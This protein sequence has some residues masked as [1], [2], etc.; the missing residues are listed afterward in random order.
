MNQRKP[1]PMYDPK[2]CLW[3]PILLSIAVLANDAVGSDNQSGPSLPLRRF[4]QS[5]IHMGTQFRVV[6]Y[7]PDEALATIAFRDAFARVAELDSRLSDYRDDSELTRLSRSSGGPAVPVSKD[8]WDVLRRSFE[9]SEETDGAFDVTVGPAVRLWRRARRTHELPT[10]ARIQQVLPRIGYQKIVFDDANH[11]VR[12]TA[13][14]MLLDLGGIAKGMATQAMLAEVKKHG[15]EKVMIVGGG[16]VTLGTA[17]PDESGWKIG[18]STPG[19]TKGVQ[20]EYLILSE[21]SVSTSG[22]ASQHIEL[23]GKRYSHIVD[24]RTG[25]ALTTRRQVTVVAP[26]GSTADALASALS[27]LGRERA[28]SVLGQFREVEAKIDELTEN[29][30]K[31]WTSAGWDRLPREKEDLSEKPVANEP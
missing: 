26:D 3:I 31:A 24:P 6:F 15:I 13:K 1:L 7:A 17:P 2:A 11:S 28:E 27:V 12:L 23:G 18:L 14:E 30:W 19:E 10:E 9:I 8:L 20:N 21:R 4:E 22:D 5:Q 25:W 29:G 16:E